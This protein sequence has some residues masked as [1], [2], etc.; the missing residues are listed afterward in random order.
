[1]ADG[2]VLLGVVVTDV[3]G[4]TEGTV[5]EGEGDVDGVADGGVTLGVAV[6]V[7]DGVEEGAVAEGVTV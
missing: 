4:V 5:D 2:G 6:I 7:V 1:V 3:V